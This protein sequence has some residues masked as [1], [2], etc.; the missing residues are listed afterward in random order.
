MNSASTPEVASK[1]LSFF[2]EMPYLS[3]D[4]ELVQHAA[5]FTDMNLGTKSLLYDCEL[6]QLTFQMKTYL[7]TGNFIKGLGN[8]HVTLEPS[9]I[10]NVKCGPDSYVPVAAGRVDSA[11]AATRST[12]APSCTTTSVTITSCAGRS[13]TLRIIG[14]LEFNGWSFQ[15][16]AYTDPILGPYQQ[17][18]GNS[19]LSVGPGFRWFICD[20][21]DFGIGSTCP[22][23]GRL[24]QRRAPH[25]NPLAFLSRPPFPLSSA[26]FI[27]TSKLVCRLTPQQLSGRRNRRRQMQPMQDGR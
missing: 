16:G 3:I 11:A 1:F 10:L 8:G 23:Q 4:P 27:N 20:K 26:D 9:V 19:Y 7:P 6:L 2:V 12:P 14:T 25:R 5:G 13:P 21:I 15:D 17:S 18:S 24:G 22:D